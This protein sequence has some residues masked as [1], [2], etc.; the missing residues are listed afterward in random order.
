MRNDKYFFDVS[1]CFNLAYKIDAEGL[2]PVEFKVKP[3]MDG[4]I[5]SIQLDRNEFYLA[6]LEKFPGFFVSVGP[7]PKLLN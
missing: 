6:I 4:C 7:Q 1:K 5:W 2:H 3:G